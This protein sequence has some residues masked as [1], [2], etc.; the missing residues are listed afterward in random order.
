MKALIVMALCL[1]LV[2]CATV[3]DKAWYTNRMTEIE[4][5]KKDGK[6]SDADYVGLKNQ[7]DSVRLE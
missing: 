3:G 7:A 2:G 6:I 4:Q 1:M 5:L